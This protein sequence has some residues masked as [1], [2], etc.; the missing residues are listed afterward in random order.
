MKLSRN[1]VLLI[2]ACVLM[3]IAGARFWSQ[4]AQQKTEAAASGKVSRAGERI[5]T[6][7]GG[8]GGKSMMQMHGDPFENLGLTPDQRKKVDALLA[9]S[10]EVKTSSDGHGHMMKKVKIHIPREKLH[11]ILTPE[12]VKK[13]EEEAPHGKIIRTAG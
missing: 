4:A 2:A 8:P 3:L 5:T 13:L 11:A 12:Q 6:T 9:A 7:T 1:H 10:T